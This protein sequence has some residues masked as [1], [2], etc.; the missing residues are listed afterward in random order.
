MTNTKRD[1]SINVFVHIPKASGSTLFSILK[2]EYQAES[3]YRFRQSDP[4]PEK[5]NEINQAFVEDPGQYRVIAGH[6]GYGLHQELKQPVNYF[7]MLREPISLI[8]S[9]YYYRRQH[10]L[11]D[12][13]LVIHA[14][15]CSLAEFV[16]SIEDNTMTRFLSGA[17]FE[18]QLALGTEQS[19][20]RTLQTVRIT[21]GGFSGDP[22][23]TAAMLET[24]K[25]NL[26]DRF[27]AFGLTEQFDQ[28]ILLLSQAFG[29][30]KIHYIKK[31]VAKQKKQAI[32]DET[33]AI[34][35]A[36]NAFDIELYD[37]AVT[38]F[39]QRIESLGAEFQQ[40]LQ[41]FQRMNPI[42]GRLSDWQ[43]NIGKSPSSA[44]RQL[45]RVKRKL[46]A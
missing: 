32:A 4:I 7:T 14:N 28:S 19:S 27:V 2:Q 17:E 10:P 24:A 35:K 41:Q 12:D 23:C 42:Y 20:F 46:F 26:S 33:L 25:Q 38:L 3:V 1:E 21:D 36:R 15:R 6:V 9:R 11:Q 40:R 30:R 31:N 37:Y 13:P 5:V 45:R 39:N 16:Q 18:A 43:V 29:W 44:I 8:V 34:I 22:I